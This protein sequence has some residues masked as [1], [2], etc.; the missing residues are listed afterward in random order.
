M[1]GAMPMTGVETAVNKNGLYLLALIYPAQNVMH[2]HFVLQ[3][4]QGTDKCSL[5]AEIHA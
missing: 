1:K 2:K 3:V 5:T 4:D